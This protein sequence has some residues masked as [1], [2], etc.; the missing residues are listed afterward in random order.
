MSHLLLILLALNVPGLLLFGIPGYLISRK[1]KSIRKKL[2]ILGIMGKVSRLRAKLFDLAIQDKLD[3]HSQTFKTFYCMY[4]EIVRHPDEYDHI[5][6]AVLRAFLTAYS[7]D[8]PSS[9]E[10]LKEK[11]E[12]PAELKPILAETGQVLY[13]VAYWRFFQM[14]ADN[15]L[16]FLA[17][18]ADFIKDTIWKFTSETAQGFVKEKLWLPI[19][20]E[21]DQNMTAEDTTARLITGS[22]MMAALAA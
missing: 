14:V 3:P 12:W 21:I 20:K 9:S 16:K 4:T 1:R 10:I 13:E 8:S 19:R 17:K 18:T 7:K 2:Y 6:E 11:E 5:A 22:Q 15:K